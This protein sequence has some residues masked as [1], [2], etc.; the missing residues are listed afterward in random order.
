M[1]GAQ[2]EAGLAWHV[3]ALGSDAANNVTGKVCGGA[4]GPPR[5]AMVLGY[6][7]GR[8]A[9]ASLQS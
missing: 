7:A 5:P 4:G 2:H 1:R 6:R 3:A 9:A 8:P